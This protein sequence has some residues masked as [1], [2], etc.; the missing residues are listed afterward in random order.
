[1]SQVALSLNDQNDGAVIQNCRSYVKGMTGNPNLTVPDPTVT[2]FTQLISAAEDGITDANTASL[3]ATQKTADKVAGIA[4]LVDAATSW[5]LQ[6]QKAS[7]GDPAI[8]A[9]FNMP[10]K[11]PSTPLGPLPQVQN[12]SLTMG[13]NPGELDSQWDPVYGRM[14]YQ[15]QYCVDPMSDD[16]WTDLTPCSASKTTLTGQTSG[17]RVWLRVRAVGAK[18]LPGPWSNPVAKIVP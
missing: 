9:S 4:A 15:I 12:L 11:S 3:L 8:I 17:S 1:M 18:G 6:V 13:D 5:A 14:S 7:K 10:V 16:G 2:V